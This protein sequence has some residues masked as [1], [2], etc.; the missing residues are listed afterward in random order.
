MCENTLEQVKHILLIIRHQDS[1]KHERFEKRVVPATHI[2]TLVLHI[3]IFQILIRHSKFTVSLL[4]FIVPCGE[5]S[6]T[7]IK[8]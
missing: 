3:V 2:W 6:F 1:I 5:K 8:T 4:C 7:T